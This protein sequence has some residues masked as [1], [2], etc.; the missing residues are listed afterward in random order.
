VIG[1]ELARDL[2]TAFLGA[3]FTNEERHLRRLAKVD[4]IEK[5]GG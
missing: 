4:E 1:V 3:S 2:A 5:R